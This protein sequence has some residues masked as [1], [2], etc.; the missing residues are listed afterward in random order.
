MKDLGKYCRSNIRYV[1]LQQ[2][3]RESCP[4]SERKQPL[5]DYLINVGCHSFIH[6]FYHSFSGF[7]DKYTARFDADP[8]VNEVTRKRWE[9]GARVSRQ[10]RDEAVRKLKVYKD[11][12]L[13][14]ILPNDGAVMVLPIGDV[15]PNYRDRPA[16]ESPA[17]PDAWDQLWL[18][19]ILGAPEVTLPSKLAQGRHASFRADNMRS[20]PSSV[21]VKRDE[22]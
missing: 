14:R 21:H 18:S 3:W 8:P 19:P 7:R 6:D 22:S 11:W 5:H 13:R 16:Y 15:M 10:Q 2:T 1:S 4:S 17:I 9:A 20:R 12:L